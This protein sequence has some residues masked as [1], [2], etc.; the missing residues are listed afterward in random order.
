MHRTNTH[1]HTPYSFSAYDSVEHLVA[2]ARDEGIV[3]LGIN[4]I[5]TCDGYA[6]FQEWC[7]RYRIFPVFN[8]EFLVRNEELKADKALQNA[9]AD[10]GF[11][12]LCGKSLSYPL[13]LSADHQNLLIASWKKTQDYIWGVIDRLNDHLK[14]CAIAISL[15]YNDVRKR[16]AKK[17]VHERHVARVLYDEMVR[18]YTTPQDFEAALVRLFGDDALAPHRHDPVSVQMEI[19]ERFL[20]RNPAIA[21]SAR[22]EHYM[23]LREAHSLILDGGGI[24][25]YSIGTIPVN[26]VKDCESDASRLAEVLERSRIFAVDFFPLRT[27]LEILKTWVMVFSNRG[28]CVTFGTGHN[29]PERLPFVPTLFGNQP[30]DQE[31]TLIGW[32]GA[33]I[34]AAHQEMRKMNR[35]GFVNNAGE[36][37]ITGETKRDFIAL[38]EQAI[39]KAAAL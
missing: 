36:L 7:G 18:A 27:E 19:Y 35:S 8:I 4:D 31:M 33:C 14:K 1:I 10:A 3:A 29:T 23:R 28:F 6:E 26:Q 32:E 5:A 2:L 22:K 12:Y 34:L 13:K 39:R 16:Y 17:I 24:P 9:P 11:L 15:D 25:C 30:L 38:G 20:V 37:L 21:S